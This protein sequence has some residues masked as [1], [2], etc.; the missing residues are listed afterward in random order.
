MASMKRGEDKHGPYWDVR[1]R[2][3]AKG[4]AGRGREL[5]R[6]TEKLAQT[7]FKRVSAIE[8]RRGGLAD[9]DGRWTVER[10][11]TEK[12]IPLRGGRV[13]AGT[14]GGWRR[15]WAP[16]RMRPQVW[17]VG[18]QWGSWP[19]EEITREAVMEWHAAMRRAGRPDSTIVR[20]HDL[21]LVVL[22][23]A[24]EIGYIP[25]PHVATNMK[26]DYKPKRITGHWRPDTIERIRSHLE[27]KAANDRPDW[28]WR[29]DRDA[30]LIAVLAYMGLRPGEALALTW[31]NVLE[32]ERGLWVTHT[33]PGL[34]DEPD[35]A[36]TIVN[37]TTKTGDDRRVPWKVAP[38]VL[39]LLMGWKARVGEHALDSPV[40][41]MHEGSHDHWNYNAWIN[42]R[43]GV[44]EP[45]LTAVGV[46]YR[47]PYH[48]RHSAITMWIYAGAPV[49]AAAKRAGHTIEVCMRNYA[50][51]WE[52]IEDS[53]E[54]YDIAAGYKA[55]R[56][57]VTP[58]RL[59][60]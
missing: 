8:D 11:F 59:V 54:R 43:R 15:R 29:R 52:D 22:G 20:A 42:W 38:F 18:H 53:D 13:S 1:W 10:F 50:G 27:Q 25:G 31:T 56:R 19:L 12:V 48:L 2:E 21:L 14:I 44:W 57:S 33:I 3:G 41:P 58:L 40:F 49:N 46:E 34:D 5:R 47:K 24:V 9:G 35:G 51:A 4:R 32:Y 37:G 60:G 36:Q 45:T 39:D 30:V 6:R 26:L 55:A 23:F 7:E 16:T 17:H 28:R